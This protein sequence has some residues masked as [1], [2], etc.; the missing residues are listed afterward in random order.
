LYQFNDLRAAGAAS[1]AVAAVPARGLIVDLGA[2]LF[3]LR[4]LRGLLTCLALCYAAW[5]L[6]PFD[7]IPTASAASLPSGSWDETRAFAIAPLAYGADTGRRMMPTEA[8]EPIADAPERPFVELTAS[9]GE[10]VGFTRALERAGVARNEAEAA[11]AM[12]GGAVPLADLQPGTAVDLRLGRRPDRTF[13]RPLETLSLRARLDL[14]LS[15]TRAGGRFVLARSPI[16]VDETPLRIEGLVGPSLYRAARA[17]GAPPRAIEDYLRAIS[18]QTDLGTLS[19]ND[20]FD[21]IVEQRRAAT[22]EA[23]TGALLYAGLERSDGSAI[24]MMPWTLGGRTSWYEASGAG[25][26]SG[27]LQRPVPGGVSS[28]FG[29]RFHPIL[30]YFRM[31][32]GIDFHAA[33]GAPIVAAADGQVIGAGWAGGYG[34]QVRVLHAG[35]LVSSYSHMSRIAAFPGMAVRQGEVIGY[36]GATGLATGPHLHYELTRGGI[37]VDPASI[38][39]IGRAQL[40]GPALAAFRQRLRTLLSVPA[41]GL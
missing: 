7:A 8:V 39:S 32:K 22:G 40:S 29:M 31:H 11:A 24:R 37:P 36:V 19:P 33:Y 20:R 1:A 35:G 30:G 12:V 9:L 25:G 17:G 28:S 5:S 14:R 26:E 4:W 16:S 15:L 13:A 2:D 34:N 3:S 38:Q 23:E 21:L 27:L 10:G 41:R 18:G 6:A